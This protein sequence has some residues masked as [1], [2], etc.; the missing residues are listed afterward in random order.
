MYHRNIC[1]TAARAIFKHD[2]GQGGPGGCHPSV[3]STVVDDHSQ[4][5]GTGLEVASSNSPVNSADADKHAI[6][7]AY[8]RNPQASRIQLADKLTSIPAEIIAESDSV[9]A[10]NSYK[11][12]ALHAQLFLIKDSANVVRTI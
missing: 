2:T 8:M 7:F 12:S 6:D 9:S 10:W 1:L 3:T 4:I 5:A 11:R